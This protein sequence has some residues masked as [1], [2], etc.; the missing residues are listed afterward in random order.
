MRLAITTSTTMESTTARTYST[1][2]KPSSP[3]DGPPVKPPGPL[4][5]GFL[6]GVLD[7]GEEVDPHE[8]EHAPDHHEGPDGH[9]GIAEELRRGEP[10]RVLEDLEDAVPEQQQA[11]RNVVQPSP[12]FSAQ[13]SPNTIRGIGARMNN[14]ITGASRAM[15]GTSIAARRRVAAFLRSSRRSSRMSSLNA[16]SAAPTSAPRSVP[17]ASS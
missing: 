13:W 2:T 11:K 4:A 15:I 7:L 16:S 6:N 14:S 1:V 12:P 17:A 10:S 3:S 8:P 5:H 9:G